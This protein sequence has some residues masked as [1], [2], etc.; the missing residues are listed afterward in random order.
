MYLRRWNLHF[1][2]FQTQAEK[3]IIT[4]WC[5]VFRFLYVII[6][7]HHYYNIIKTLFQEI[8]QYL[9][10]NFLAN[11]LAISFTETSKRVILFS[12]NTQTMCSVHMILWFKDLYNK[13]FQ[14]VSPLWS[15]P[16][17]STALRWWVSY[18]I[19]A[20][21]LRYAWCLV[22]CTLLRYAQRSWS[23]LHRLA[24]KQACRLAL[25]RLSGAGN[26][27]MV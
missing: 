27:P 24:C 3:S 16:K 12:G 11:S 1:I 23:N 26:N 22:L 15:S 13:I 7:W 2:K 20:A 17:A 5:C 25:R 6:V 8:W 18:S 10:C 19:L 4:P 14:K 21:P 9:D